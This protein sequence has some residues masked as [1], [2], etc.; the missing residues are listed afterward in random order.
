MKDGVRV[1]YWLESPNWFVRIEPLV[2]RYNNF[3]KWQNEKEEGKIADVSEC[4][5]LTSKIFSE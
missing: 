1:F 3:E 5:H 2:R 4:H